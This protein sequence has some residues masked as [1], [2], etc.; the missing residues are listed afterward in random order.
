[1]EGKAGTRIRG[2][3]WGKEKEGREGKGARKKNKAPW[4]T[5]DNWTTAK[6]AAVAAVV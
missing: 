3:G 4:K 1:M 6:I 5:L 2:E